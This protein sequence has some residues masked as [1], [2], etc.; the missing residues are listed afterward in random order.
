MPNFLLFQKIHDL[1]SLAHKYEF[2]DLQKSIS[3]C[4]IRSLTSDNVCYVYDVAAHYYLEDLKQNCL[5]Y[6]DQHAVECMKTESFCELSDTS[7]VEL[8]QRGSF[9]A[10]EIEIFHG[11]SRWIK[12][13]SATVEQSVMTRIVQCV[14]LPLI[15]LSDL[16]KEVRQ[17]GFISSEN[18]L[19]A[20]AE[21]QL[22]GGRQANCRGKMSKSV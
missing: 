20:V 11:A 16:L 18:L 2:P 12:H 9:F 4:L 7:L 10:A 3:D 6:L 17:S 19:D 13:N 1:L 5:T 8:L 21:Q 14:R 22:F 15:D